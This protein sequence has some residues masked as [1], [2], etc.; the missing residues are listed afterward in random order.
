MKTL[1]IITSYLRSSSAPGRPR[2]ETAVRAQSAGH[3]YFRAVRSFSNIAQNDHSAVS[4]QI[5]FF[6]F[7]TPHGGPLGGPPRE[8]VIPSIGRTVDRRIHTPHPPQEACDVCRRSSED[9]CQR[10]AGSPDATSCHVVSRAFHEQVLRA[11]PV[12]TRRARVVLRPAEAE[13]LDG[14]T[15]IS[16]I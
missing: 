7:C 14:S 10:G 5:F 2:H 16:C 8:R 3:R 6:F 13:L 11:V 1:R 9:I 12:S 4:T 15:Q